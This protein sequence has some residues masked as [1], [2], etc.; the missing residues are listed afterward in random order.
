MENAHDRIPI[1]NYLFASDVF[2]NAYV[3]PFRDIFQDIRER[4]S[5]S[6]VSLP[7]RNRVLQIP[8]YDVPPDAP[9]R[10]DLTPH[11]V[12]PWETSLALVK[13]PRAEIPVIRKTHVQPDSGYSTAHGSPMSH[14]LL[15]QTVW[16]TNAKAPNL[17]A[18]FPKVTFYQRFKLAIVRVIAGKKE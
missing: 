6:S 14:Y 5:A 13:P 1:S 10:L 3:I 12:L 11:A 7:D 17:D 9:T 15:S 16:P 8:Y 18:E 2:G 4:L